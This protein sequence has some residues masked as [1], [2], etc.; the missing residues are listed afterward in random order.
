[1]RA[2]IILAA[3]AVVLV[4]PATAGGCDYYCRKNGD[5][6]ATTEDTAVTVGVMEHFLD[7]DSALQEIRRVLKPGVP[8]HL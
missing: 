7:T 8:S 5:T 1:M 6:A 2:L 4:S 3:L